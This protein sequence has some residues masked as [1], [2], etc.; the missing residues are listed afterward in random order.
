MKK[1]LDDGKKKSENTIGGQPQLF[2][3]EEL[4]GGDQ[5][6]PS[7]KPKDNKNKFKISSG[8][9]K[10]TVAQSN[11]SERKSTTS[12]LSIPKSGKVIISTQ[13]PTD[14]I[15]NNSATNFLGFETEDVEGGDQALPDQP[16]TE[17]T[18][19]DVSYKQDSFEDLSI[20]EP[21]IQQNMEEPELK[22]NLEIPDEEVQSFVIDNNINSPEK[23]L[24]EYNNIPSKTP[25]AKTPGL[26]T[27]KTKKKGPTQKGD[28]TKNLLKDWKEKEKKLQQLDDKL[29]VMDAINVKAINKKKD[30]IDDKLKDLERGFKI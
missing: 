17:L 5:A 8:K 25:I 19:Q 24:E 9:N 13:K 23:N 4:E 12:I 16:R 15:K 22:L 28:L 1:I 20:N 14:I 29:F 11:K 10:S 2:Q 6:L 3:M 26:K 18:V 30:K 21:S 27:D 7:E